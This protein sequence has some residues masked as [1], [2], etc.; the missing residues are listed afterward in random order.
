MLLQSHRWKEGKL[1][2]TEPLP[3]RVQTLLSMQIST[4]FVQLYS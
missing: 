4:A 2:M 3:C 1:R